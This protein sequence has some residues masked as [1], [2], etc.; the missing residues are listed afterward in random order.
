MGGQ[1]RW[2]AGPP[3]AQ[4]EHTHTPRAHRLREE[5]RREAR[6]GC[7]GLAASLEGGGP[8]GWL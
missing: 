4:G 7:A 2:I 1:G 3:A 6:R 5:W 8:E